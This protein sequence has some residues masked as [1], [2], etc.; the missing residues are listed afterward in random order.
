[1]TYPLDITTL[2][3][4]TIEVVAVD[5]WDAESNKISC[6]VTIGNPSGTV[7]AEL[8][9]V[10]TE[11]DFVDGRIVDTKDK[12]TITVKGGTIVNTPLTFAGKTKTVG[13]YH[14]TAA[15]MN[16]T[17]KFKEYT[18]STLSDFYNS[19]T[20]FSVEVLYINHAPSGTQG[21]VCG[22]QKPGG[23]GLAESNGVPYFFTYIGASG[24]TNLSIGSNSSKTEL[25]HLIGTFL[26][27][28]ATN[29]TYTAIYLNGQVVKTG[30]AAGKVGVYSTAG[31]GDAFCIGGDI[32]SS[33]GSN[34]FPMTDFVVADV[35]FYAHAL[36]YKQA[37]TAYNNAVAYFS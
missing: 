5:S 11:L 36:N 17:L 13:A 27:D 24:S 21:I 22:T 2:G 12:F 37:E 29:T 20:G 16:T 14:V 6:E 26:Y 15:G 7:T 34:E 33:G 9:E 32:N 25:N 19:S 30:S 18:V 8:P 35:K 23:W 31:I 28:S 3:V 1:M 4:Y 10:Y